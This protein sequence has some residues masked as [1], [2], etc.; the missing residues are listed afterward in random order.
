MRY[1]GLTQINLIL[2]FFPILSKSID[3]LQEHSYFPH[4]GGS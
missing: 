3:V 4:D 1:R 2:E